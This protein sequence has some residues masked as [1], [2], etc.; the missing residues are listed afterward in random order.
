MSKYTKVLALSVCLFGASTLLP[1]GDGWFAQ[2]C[3]KGNESVENAINSVDGLIGNVSTKSLE[4]IH[5][6]LKCGIPAGKW[7]LQQAARTPIFQRHIGQE[8]VNDLPESELFIADHVWSFATGIYNTCCPPTVQKGLS[9]LVDSATDNRVAK[10]EYTR[11]ALG[12]TNRALQ[13]S[14]VQF[15]AIKYAGKNVNKIALVQ[16]NI[17][18][19]V[20]VEGLER[21]SSQKLGGLKGVALVFTGE[22]LQNITGQ[23]SEK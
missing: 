2:G 23:R 16:G 3:E 20:V 17:A 7:V 18:E 12:M 11:A 19:Y 1:K 8:V 21:L 22:T 13:A 4:D 15:L 14:F 9:S 5:R 6:A 10:H